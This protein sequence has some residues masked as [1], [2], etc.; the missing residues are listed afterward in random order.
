MVTSTWGCFPPTVPP[1]PVGTDPKVQSYR[2]DH[3]RICA[4]YRTWAAFWQVYA[5]AGGVLSGTGGVVSVASSTAAP[6]NQNPNGAKV[7]GYVALGAGALAAVSAFAA[8]W[9]TDTAAKDRCDQWLD[10]AS[11][12][13]PSPPG[14][15]ASS[16][17][18]TPR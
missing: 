3:V 8:K 2:E 16:P 10:W 1:A 4:G 12:S 11:G 6:D 5:I 18:S 17:D 15:T 9:Y 7:G 14:A 13:V